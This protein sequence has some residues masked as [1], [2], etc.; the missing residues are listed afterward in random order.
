M[1]GLKSALRLGELRKADNVEI[2]PSDP[3]D[4]RLR[5][6]YGRLLATIRVDG[7]DVGEV[8]VAEGLARPWGG[9]RA[10]WCD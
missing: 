7:R 9:R 6:R 1:L 4:G 5:N 10:S 8:L 2:I 3:A